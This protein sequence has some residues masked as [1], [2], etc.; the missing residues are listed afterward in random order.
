[1]AGE[2]PGAGDLVDGVVAA[3]VLADDEHLA[4]SRGETGRVHTAGAV[5]QRLALPEQVGEPSDDIGPRQRSGPP[6]AGHRERRVE[7][8]AAAHAARRR[9]GADGLVLVRHGGG[10]RVEGDGDDVEL[11]LGPQRGVGAVGHP[12]RPAEPLV[13]DPPGGELEVV[14]GRAHGRPH[15]VRGGAGP[16]EADLEGLLDRHPVLA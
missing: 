3:D 15:P 6:G 5:E 12:V 8:V 13:V 7:G 10:R 11:L 9:A 14:T 4:V 16:L 2:Q 1:M